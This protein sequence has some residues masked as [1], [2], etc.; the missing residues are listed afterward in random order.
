MLM[1]LPQPKRKPLDIIKL[2]TDLGSIGR[3]Y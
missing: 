2:V 3:R 1:L